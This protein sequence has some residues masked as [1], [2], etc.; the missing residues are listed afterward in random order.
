MSQTLILRSSGVEGGVIKGELFPI[1]VVK[2]NAGA[3]IQPSDFL[4]VYS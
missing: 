1:I 2:E 4:I 3:G